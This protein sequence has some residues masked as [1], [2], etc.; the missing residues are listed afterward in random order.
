V[1]PLGLAVL[2]AED[3][4]VN[5][6]VA[7]R[8]LHHLGCTTTIV[9]N[10]AEA[11][12]VAA[13]GVFDVI[14]MDSHMPAMDGLEAT[15]RIRQLPESAGTVPII[16]LTAAA[17]SGDR[18]RCLAAGMDGYL[19]KPFRPEQLCSVLERFRGNRRSLPEPSVAVTDS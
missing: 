10:G 17:L 4:P 1:E 13:R 15:R 7:E 11:V 8:I 2:L 12:A 18:E 9:A 14:L 6:K 3:N 5:Q 19:A 16:A